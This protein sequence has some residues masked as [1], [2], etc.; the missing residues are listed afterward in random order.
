MQS[1]LN[2]VM[3]FLI[4]NYSC[5]YCCFTDK[6]IASYNLRQKSATKIH[7]PA[8]EEL[9]R[10]TWKMYLCIYDEYENIALP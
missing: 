6:V 1:S 4:G 8:K 10:R 7:N 2:Y 5:Y 3:T 9:L